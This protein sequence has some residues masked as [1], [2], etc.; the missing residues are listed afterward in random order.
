MSGRTL[1]AVILIALGVATFL[2]QGVVYATRERAPE[3]AI[4]EHTHVLTV[5][6][7]GHELPIPPLFGVAAYVGGIALLTLKP[8]LHLKR[9]RHRELMQQVGWGATPRHAS[10]RPGKFRV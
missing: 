1:L 2:Y 10:G 9:S 6:A 8:T 3:L 7:K 4:T 5:P